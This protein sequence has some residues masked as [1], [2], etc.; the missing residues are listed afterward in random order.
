MDFANTLSKCN[1]SGNCNFIILD[2]ASRLKNHNYEGWYQNNVSDD[3][4]I[5]IGN[6]ICDQYTINVNTLSKNLTNNCG[7]S[8][9][10]FIKDGDTTLIKLLGISGHEEDENNE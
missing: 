6:G 2:N 8:Y 4:G 10:Y 9:G 3:S 1:A 5:W 7:L